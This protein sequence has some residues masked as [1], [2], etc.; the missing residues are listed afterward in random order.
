MLTEDDIREALHACFDTKNSYGQPISIVDLGLVESIALADDPDAPGA[1]IPGVRPRQSL[2]LTLIPSSAD[3]DATAILVAQIENRLAGLEQLSRVTVHL[4]ESSAWS[5]S[6]I[7]P[8]GRKLLK[9]DA[10]LFPIL[11]SRVR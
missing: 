7:T 2:A 1:G 3:A 11:N 6:R 8:E 9:L 10:A 4:L 5:P